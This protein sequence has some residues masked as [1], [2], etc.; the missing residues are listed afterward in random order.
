[1]KQQCKKGFTIIEVILVMG[2]AGLIFLMIFAALPALG[3]AQRDSRRRD[4]ISI[5]LRKIKDYQ[6]NNRGMLPENLKDFKEDYL[7]NNFEDPL[8]EEYELEEKKCGNSN[9]GTECSESMTKTN[10]TFPNGY[11]VFVHRQAS[12]DGEK[13]VVSKNVRKIAIQ[14]KLEGGGIYCANT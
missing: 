12:C 6:T 2:I 7:G 9:V 11:Q 4:D 1:M 3:R 14:Y 8:G 10:P 13:A 5:L